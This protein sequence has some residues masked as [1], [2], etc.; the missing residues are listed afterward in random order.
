MSDAPTEELLAKLSQWQQG[1]FVLDV[2]SFIFRDQENFDDS[3]EGDGGVVADDAVIGFAV[4]SQT[5]E[6]ARAPNVVPYVTLC[7]LIKIDD[8]RLEDLNKGHAPRYGL[9]ENTPENVVVDFTRTMSISKSLL[10]TW[11]PTRGCPEMKQQTEFARSLETFFGRYA[12]PEEFVDSLRSFRKSITETYGRE[13]SDFGKA[14]RSLR[15]L[16]VLPHNDWFSKDSIEVTFIA[17]LLDEADRELKDKG[18]IFKL[19]SEKIQ[20]IKWQAPFSINERPLDVIT[21]GALSALEYLGSYRLDVNSLS[22]ARRY[23][24]PTE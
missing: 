22:F 16:R 19:L 2:G 1:D 6:V 13:A 5:C 12:F 18:M 17:I 24:R 14:I 3:G 8:K 10:T 15:E 7:P 4:V 21:L 23:K 11:E 20:S 9:L